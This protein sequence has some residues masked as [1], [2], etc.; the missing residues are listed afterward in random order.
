MTCKMNFLEGVVWRLTSCAL[1]LSR[2]YSFPSLAETPH[3]VFLVLTF[4]MIPELLLELVFWPGFEHPV[5]L[6]ILFLCA[7]LLSRPYSFLSLAETPHYVFLVLIVP[8][9]KY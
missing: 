5:V 6:R 4:S 3:Y 7:L 9:N 2:P 1:L 8:L